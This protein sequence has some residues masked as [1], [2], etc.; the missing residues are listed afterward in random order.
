MRDT[1]RCPGGVRGLGLSE[2]RA[3]TNKQD[4]PIPSLMHTL[5]R[6]K[7][8]Q[9][10]PPKADPVVPMGWTAPYAGGGALA[11]P[12]LQPRGLCSYTSTGSRVAEGE[13]AKPRGGRGGVLRSKG[14]CTN[15]GPK[16]SLPSQNL[17]L[18]LRNRLF[19]TY[20]QA[21]QMWFSGAEGP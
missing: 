12:I 13:G 18:A 3:L 14:L 5:C 9:G 4:G 6:L 8:L 1:L 2:T 17:I 20:C 7:G 10:E 15:N 11:A 19:K 16:L 21:A